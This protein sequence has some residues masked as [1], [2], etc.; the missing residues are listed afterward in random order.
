M[1]A[2]KSE[3]APSWVKIKPEEVEKIV[4]DLAKRGESPSK[5]GIILRDQHGVPKTKLLGKK[6]CQI[7]KE[8]NMEIQTD[9]FVVSNKI[10]T[11]K[12]HIKDNKHDY[13]A[14]KSLTKSL[15]KQYR[16]K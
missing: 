3:K 6:I 4:L 10:E 12:K 14:S 9:K 1:A 15:W 11:L 8:N 13:S 2:K 7:L 5:I 16:L